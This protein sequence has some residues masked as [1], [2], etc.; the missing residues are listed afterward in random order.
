MARPGRQE[1]LTSWQGLTEEGTKWFSI[2]DFQ[3]IFVIGGLV[4]Q[5]YPHVLSNKCQWMLVPML[6]FVVGKALEGCG[7]SL[8]G[9]KLAGLVEAM[10]SRPPRF[11][12][13]TP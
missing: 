6:G 3:N 1:L 11:C 13:E 8:R 4:P 9:K 5:G 12:R 7:M 2:L 10:S